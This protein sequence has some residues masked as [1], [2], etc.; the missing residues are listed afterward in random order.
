MH[1]K[2]TP[3]HINYEEK[4]RED[5][6]KLYKKIIKT[7]TYTRLYRTRIIY[8]GKKKGMAI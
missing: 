5:W 3:E 8:E 4:N 6:G 1:Y 2:Y 7:I